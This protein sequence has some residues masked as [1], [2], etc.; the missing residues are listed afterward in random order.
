LRSLS[1]FA[2]KAGSR[3]PQPRRSFR[4]AARWPLRPTRW[5]CNRDTS[6]ER[7]C[8]AWNRARPAR[9]TRVRLSP[10]GLWAIYRGHPAVLGHT[11][12]GDIIKHVARPHLRLCTW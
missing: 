7:D 11:S 5:P 4:A 2:F 8:R 3:R 10:G 1:L 6:V 12:T 9:A